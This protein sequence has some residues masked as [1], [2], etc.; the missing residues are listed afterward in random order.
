LL[1]NHNSVLPNFGVIALCSFFYT[2]LCPKTILSCVQNL[3]GEH[4]PHQPV[5]FFLVVHFISIF[6]FNDFCQSHGPLIIIPPPQNVGG[7][8]YNG[9]A[10]SR[11]SV[12]LLVSHYCVRSINLILIEGFS[13]LKCSPQQGDVQ[14]PCCPCVS[15][16]S[17]LKVKYQTIK[18]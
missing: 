13:W 14:N 10:F 15:S 18:Y 11:R 7:G 9:F 4:H 2:F 16:R 12:G 3:L 6:W 5:L 17:Q 1:N 8:G